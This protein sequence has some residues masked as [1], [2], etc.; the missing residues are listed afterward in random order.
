LVVLGEIQS[1][2]ANWSETKNEIIIASPRIGIEEA[3][4]V[5]DETVGDG[6]FRH[7]LL[8]LETHAAVERPWRIT[9]S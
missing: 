4:A 5:I 3:A 9:A 1:C 6:Q 2:A 7:A 8:Q